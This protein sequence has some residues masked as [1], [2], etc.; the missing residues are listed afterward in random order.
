[1]RI[2]QCS[3]SKSAESVFTLALASVLAVRILIRNTVEAIP[4]SAVMMHFRS[5]LYLIHHRPPR[6]VTDNVDDYYIIHI[7]N[8]KCTRCTVQLVNYNKILCIHSRDIFDCNDSRQRCK[9]H[10][11]KKKTGSLSLSVPETV[12]PPSKHNP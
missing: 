2:N 3:L 9:F 11:L 12:A 5:T 1:M 6:H 4:D 10:E 7:M 8:Y